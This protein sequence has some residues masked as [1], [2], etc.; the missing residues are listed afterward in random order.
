MRRLRIF[1][2]LC[3]ALATCACDVQS[4]K[5]HLERV[6]AALIKEDYDLAIQECNE[7]IRIEPDGLDGYVARRD[8]YIEMEDYESALRDADHVIRL[9]SDDPQEYSTRAGIHLQMEDHDAAI[10]DFSRAIDLAPAYGHFY[11][12]RGHAFSEKRDDDR[13][14]ADYQRAIALGPDDAYAYN[15]LA[16]LHVTRSDPKYRKPAEA[17]TLALKCVELQR[18]E[19]T[20]DTLACAYAENGDFEKAVDLQ[21]EA[22]SLTDSGEAETRFRRRLRGFEEKKTYLD[23]EREDEGKGTE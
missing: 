23:Q 20:L 15:N 21:R 3:A 6:D 11:R 17:L 10:D 2:P 7:A 14:V 22:V 9:S 4:A 18:D 16:W 13:A 5:K 8:V 1:L 19:N 12:M